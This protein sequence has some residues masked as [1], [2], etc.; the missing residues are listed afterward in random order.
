MSSTDI[1]IFSVEISNFFIKKYR[2]RLHFSTQLL[3]LLTLFRSLMD[4]SR[5]MAAN[6]DDVSKI[7]YSTP[8]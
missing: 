7:G 1:S 5:Y 6:F 4:V 2:Y 3:L 8:F